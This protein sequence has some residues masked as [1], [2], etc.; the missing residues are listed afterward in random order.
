MNSATVTVNFEKQPL[1]KILGD[2]VFEYPKPI[3]FELLIDNHKYTIEP[4][5]EYLK[6][7]IKRVKK[8]GRSN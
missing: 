3:K 5:G 6:I 7:F 2:N 4:D 8:H 1:P